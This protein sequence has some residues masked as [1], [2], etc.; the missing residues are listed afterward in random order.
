MTQKLLVIGAGPKA[1]SL[2]GKAQ[3]LKSL[4]FAGVPQVVIID[5][6]GVAAHWDGLSGF[7][8][9]HQHLG[10]PPEKDVGFP[11]RS[12]EWGAY[13]HEIDDR[14]LRFS[15]H[16]FKV[17]GDVVEPLFTWVDRGR[18]QPTHGEWANYLKWVAEQVE[19]DLVQGE[20]IEISVTDRGKW[21]LAIRDESGAVKHLEGD[22]LVI[23]GPGSVKENITTMDRVFNPVTFW[24]NVGRF[25]NQGLDFCVAGVGETAGA[26]VAAAV[27][28]LGLDSRVFVVSPHGFIYSRGESLL[29]NR[30]YSDPSNWDEIAPNHRREFIRRTDRGVFSVAVQGVINASHVPVLC[31]PG[32][33]NLDSLRPS[34]HGGVRVEVQYEGTVREHE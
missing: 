31:L 16:R 27:R 19:P 3:V 29:E 5:K 8:D 24:P 4:G 23:T 34:D 18:L 30:V 21:S 12:G 6:R 9:G 20:V 32:R 26:I 28:R 33:A 1:L 10:T 11:Y 25:Q 13:N 15:W 7:T 17:L 2:A 22:G 14:M